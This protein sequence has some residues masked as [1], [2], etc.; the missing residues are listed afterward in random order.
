MREE[1]ERATRD[2]LAMAVPEPA[3]ALDG[4]F[5]EGDA[6]PLGPGAAP[7]SRFAGV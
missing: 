7:W 3:S 2:A 4:V 6:E 5:C 1:I